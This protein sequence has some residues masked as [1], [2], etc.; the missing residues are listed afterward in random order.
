MIGVRRAGRLQ[1]QR[2]KLRDKRVERHG[3][4]SNTIQW[5]DLSPGMLTVARQTLDNAGVMNVELSEGNAAKLHFPDNTFDVLHN[6]HILD[7]IPLVEIT[8]IITAFKRVLKPGGRLI[9]LNM[10]RRDAQ[11]TTW[12]ERVYPLVAPAGAVYH[13]RLSS[14]VDGTDCHS[15]GL[16]CRNA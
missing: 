13:R 5:V 1:A 7:L 4:R 6:G 11:I 10:S 3:A 8:G 9:L 14:G 16:Q 2:G 15:G 12:C